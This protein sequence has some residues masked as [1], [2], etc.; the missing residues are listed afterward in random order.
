MSENRHIPVTNYN[1]KIGITQVR[2]GSDMYHYDKLW[3]T[4][5]EKGFSQRRLVN[6]YGISES[7]LYRLRHNQSVSMHSIDTL[8]NILGCDITDIVTYYR[9]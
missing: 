2:K 8:C 6:E 9:E 1:D 5:K 4:M 3:Q 7:L